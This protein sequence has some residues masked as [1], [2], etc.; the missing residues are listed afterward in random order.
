LF[1]FDFEGNLYGRDIEVEF[2]AF[3]RA[4]AK[5]SSVEA[6]KEQMQEDCRRARAI[7]AAAPFEPIAAAH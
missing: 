2:I 4:D 7:L 5:F 3:V 1:L 6:L